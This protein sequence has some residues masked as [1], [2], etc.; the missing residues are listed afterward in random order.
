LFSDPS[1]AAIGL[2]TL[3]LHHTT[4]KGG[5]RNWGGWAE[6]L[7]LED[8]DDQTWSYRL[9]DYSTGIVREEIIRLGLLA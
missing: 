9:Y 3:W 6:M 7:V 4:C 1:T 2:Q 5:E 8:I